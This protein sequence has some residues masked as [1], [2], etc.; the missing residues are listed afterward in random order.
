MTPLTG[1]ADIKREEDDSLFHDT[2]LE[3]MMDEEQPVEEEDDLGYTGQVVEDEIEHPHD[4]FV[5][6]G[7][8]E[9]EEDI[10]LAEDELAGMEHDMFDEHSPG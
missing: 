5:S 6:Q 4:D 8:E 2:T 10:Y 9:A 7:P 3:D 1:F